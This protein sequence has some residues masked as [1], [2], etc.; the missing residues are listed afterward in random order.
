MTID[1]IIFGIVCELMSG[2]Q[3]IQIED[4]MSSIVEVSIEQAWLQPLEALLESPKQPI[5]KLSLISDISREHLFIELDKYIIALSVQ[6]NIIWRLEDMCR[7]GVPDR[8]LYAKPRIDKHNQLRNDYMEVIDDLI[9]NNIQ[10]KADCGGGEHWT[11]ES[12]GGLIDKCSVNLMKI[13]TTKELPQTEATATR[14]KLL[15]DQH[16]AVVEAFMVLFSH[17]ES[18]S[19]KIISWKSMKMY[20]NPETNPHLAKDYIPQ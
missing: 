3:H 16:E 4:M 1:S 17:V 20:N 18:G 9:I 13:I 2:K 19:R 11:S 8:I 15:K 7:T 14:L 12:F 6:N 10:N 5:P